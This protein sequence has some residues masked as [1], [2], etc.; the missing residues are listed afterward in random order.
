MEAKQATPHEQLIAELMD[1]N[2][3]KTEREHA[4]AREIEKLR[5]E[6]H[7]LNAALACENGHFYFANS[8][9]ND[10]PYCKLEAWG[11]RAKA[12]AIERVELIQE[13]KDLM[14]ANEKLREELGFD[15]ICDIVYN[16]DSQHNQDSQNKQEVQV[17]CSREQ[18]RLIQFALDF[19]SRIG[20][21]QFEEIF[22]H[23]SV[24]KV[25]KRSCTV[26]KEIKVGTKCMQGV[27]VKITKNKIHCEGQWSGKKEIRKFN[28]D[29]VTICPDW[30]NYHA[31]KDDVRM[32]LNAIKNLINNTLYNG[33]FGIH[34]NEIDESC[35][36]AYDLLQII[37][38]EF[39][40][41]NPDPK[42]CTVDSSVHLTGDNTNFKVSII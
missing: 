5:A 25:L 28:K 6:I 33:H 9:E 36:T 17:S 13:N 18:L 12:T 1:S 37:R 23:P 31:I 22:H 32:R 16:K 8:K 19:Y 11:H 34:S 29:E 14:K 42:M 10:C 15:E 7:I 3:P 39:W 21:F 38:H 27:V 4:A 35:R 41:K 24:D 20:I 2:V 26:E 40:K 30:G